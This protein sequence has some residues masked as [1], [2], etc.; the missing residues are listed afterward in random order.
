MTAHP[1]P[2]YPTSTHPASRHTDDV[3]I[4]VRP[5]RFTDDIEAMRRCLELVGLRARIESQAGRWVDLVAGAGMVALHSVDSS[6]SGA[7]AG[8]TQLSFEVA[9]PDALVERLRAAGFADAQVVDEAYGRDVHVTDPLGDPLILNGESD[10]LYGYRL[11]AP[12]APDER[13][14]VSPT[15]FTD[16]QGHYGSFLEAL[17]LSRIGTGDEWFA[18]YAVAQGGGVHLHRTGPGPLPILEGPGAVHLT[19]TTSE[20]IEELADRL[21]AAGYHPRVAHE[22]FGS[23]VAVTD[24]DGREIEVH[25]S[26]T[27]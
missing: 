26:V 11:N 4:V 25:E 16:P 27:G 6:A 23:S 1:A 15:R 10:D 8:E 18:A 22:D 12:V 3:P 13:V 19:F 17:G 20:P 21:A 9:D 14:S 5:V 2:S 7:R 24:P